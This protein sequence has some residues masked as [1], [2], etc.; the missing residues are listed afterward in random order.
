[1]SVCV[2]TPCG[3]HAWL[4]TG[5]GIGQRESNHTCA[6]A[7]QANHQDWS[8]QPNNLPDNAAHL[9]IISIRLRN[10]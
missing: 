10:K 3:Q 2:A 9:N 6:S 5:I 4:R 1:M 8:M 7:L